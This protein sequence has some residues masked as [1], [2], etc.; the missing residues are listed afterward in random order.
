MIIHISFWIF[1]TL[2]TII[3]LVWALFFVKGDGYLS[4][5]DNVLALVPALAISCFSWIIYSIYIAVFKY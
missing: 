5:L 1:P 4:G 2:I 3:S